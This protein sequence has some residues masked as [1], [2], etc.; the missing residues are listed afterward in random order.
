MK[1]IIKKL[2]KNLLKK[3]NYKI[4][5]L[6][7]P[8]PRQH[9][10][11]FPSDKEIELI[12]KCKGVL[13]LGAHRGTE[14]GVYDWFNKKVLWIEADPNLHEE[15]LVNIRKHYNQS[16]I[17]ALIGNKNKK[18]IPFY[19]SNND[20]A[21]SSIFSF[22]EDVKKGKL[23]KERKFF[24]KDTIY[25]NMCRLDDILELKK[26]D[27]KEYDHWIFDIQGAELIALKGAEKSLQNCKSIQ[28]EISKKNYYENGAKWNE[29]KEFMEK[30]NFDLYNK[31]ELDHAEVLFIKNE[32]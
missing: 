11:P 7:Y 21:C 23:W 12:K 16:S 3:L 14:A 10:F 20:G 30:K 4:I 9:P 22:S 19:I 1:K 28:L 31:P 13:H 15:L 26:I 17:C 32:N 8:R 24:T 2:I 18:N 25:L 6:D 27:I 29:I 5:K